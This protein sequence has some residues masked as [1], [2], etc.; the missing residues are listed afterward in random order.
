[1]EKA[2][3]DPE[4]LIKLGSGRYPRAAVD[5]DIENGSIL[6]GQISG[7]VKR[8]QSSGE[9]VEEIMAE[10]FVILQKLGGLPC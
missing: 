6:A 10:V 7:L 9:I 8:V 5:G 3:A 4:T 2:G 1:V